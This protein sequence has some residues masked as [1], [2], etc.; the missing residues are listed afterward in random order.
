[1]IKRELRLSPRKTQDP[2]KT[3][4]KLER[5]FGPF[6]TACLTVR[7]LFHSILD[8]VIMR[9]NHTAAENKTADSNENIRVCRY[10]KKK[11]IAEVYG[12]KEK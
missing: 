5:K 12:V 2:R 3:L 10:C 9:T 7:M 1:M 8:L 6:P 4:E 11:R